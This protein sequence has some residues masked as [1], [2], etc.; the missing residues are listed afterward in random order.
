M[1]M[2]ESKVKSPWKPMKLRLA[3]MFVVVTGAMITV[4]IATEVS[5]LT[6]GR[7]TVT[8]KGVAVGVGVGV[9]NLS[10]IHI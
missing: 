4:L 8:P 5:K 3:S 9:T 1:T 7:D 6:E 10:L 2:V